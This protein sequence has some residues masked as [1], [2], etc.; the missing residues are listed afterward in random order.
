MGGVNETTVAAAKK[1]EAFRAYP[2]LDQG[3]AGYWT[4]GYGNT[5]GVTKDT[6]PITEQ[7]ATETLLENLRDASKSVD[8]LVT[9]PLTDNQRGALILF[10]LNEGANA[11]AYSTLLH[12][13]NQRDYAGALAQWPKWVYEHRHGVAVRSQGLANRRAAEQALWLTPDPVVTQPP[14]PAAPSDTPKP[15]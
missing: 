14:A 1:L 7:Q 4:N 12:L 11:L 9:V 6:P 15:P 3:E 13:L 8:L 5:H 2:Y 10:V